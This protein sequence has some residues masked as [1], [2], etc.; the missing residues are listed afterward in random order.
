L[1]FPI[2]ND[3]ALVSLHFPL[4]NTEPAFTMKNNEI[5]DHGMEFTRHGLTRKCQRG[6]RSEAIKLVL[7]H[8]D[9][10][11]HAGGTVSALSISRLRSAELRRGG[12]E[13]S[14]VDQAEKVVLIVADDGAI[15]TLIN[16]P[17]WF[18]RFHQGADRLGHRRR[19]LRRGRR[20]HCRG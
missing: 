9:R 11:M 6:V 19:S 10:D 5:N 13:A 7:S 14:L 15:L 8:Y 18:A 20:S 2:V 4:V 17:T 12:I 1:D 16:R 3:A